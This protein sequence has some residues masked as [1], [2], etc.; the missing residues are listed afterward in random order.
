MIASL[1]VVEILPR[2][3]DILEHGTNAV[4][5][6]PPGAGKTTIVPLALLEREA[7]WLGQ[8]RLIVVEPRRVAVRSA[9]VRM[10]ALLG[11]RTGQTVGYRTRI[12]RVVSTQTRIEVVTEGLLVRRLIADPLLEGVSGVLFDEVHERSL[13]GDTALAFVLDV[14]R[15]FRPDLRLLAMSATL[16]GEIFTTCLKAPLLESKGRQYPVEVQYQPDI[17]QHRDLP[18][19]CCQVIRRLWSDKEGSILVFLPGVGEIRR[20]QAIL[21][22]EFPIF[23]LYGEQPVEEQYQALDSASGRRIVLATSIAETSVTV[24]GVRIVIDGG[25]RRLPQ[26]DPSTGLAKLQTRRISRAT[27]EQRAGRAGREAP[28]LAVRLW[29]EMTQRGLMVQEVPAI[30]EAD[31]SDFALVTAAWQEVMGTAPL[32]L[33]LIEAPPVGALAGGQEIVRALGAL[34]SQN[35]L[36]PLGHKMVNLGT[37]PRLAAILCAAETPREKVTAACLA[38][39]LE[40][41]DPFR[42]KIGHISPPIDIRQRLSLFSHDD[43]RAPRGITH[44][45]RHSAQRFL[46]RMGEKAMRALSPDMECAGRL[47]AA[48][49][50]DRLA[51]LTSQAGRYRL[52]GGGSA[53]VA[54]SDE[55]A[56]EKLLAAAVFHVK[57]GTDMTLAAPVTVETLPASVTAQLT[58]RREGSFDGPSGRVIVRQRLRLGALVL[59]DRHVPATPEDVQ[60]ALVAKVQADLPRYLEWTKGARQFQARVALARAHY[61]PQIPDISNEALV[62]SMVWLVPWLPGIDRLSQ[63]KELDVQAMLKACFSYEELQELERQLPAFVTL[64]AG[65]HM[66]DYTGAIPALSARAQAFYG[67]TRLPS[68]VGGIVPLHAVLLSPAGRPQAV[69][70]DLERFWKN[71]WVDLRRDMRGRYPRHNWPE[72]PAEA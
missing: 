62:Q 51:Q 49:F 50:P 18:E 58:E 32:D 31:L 29:S 47:I 13:D 26:R 11:E 10:A 41:R 1:P 19:R 38:A 64:K 20:T 23:P 70:A 33:S 52:A 67:T 34:D 55:L 28:G 2:L 25:W 27:A 72:N 61:A 5:V 39:L 21:G 9:A 8:G 43:P 63:L 37:H 56:H 36:T 48:G 42:S 59:R 69:T 4:L 35:R 24:S 57:R 60:P 6:A 17:M 68:L 30:R 7:V 66:I 14:Q 22:E 44:V 65:R 3:Y 54:S 53:R 71:G 46:R 40:E 12:D 45:L 15:S 16:E